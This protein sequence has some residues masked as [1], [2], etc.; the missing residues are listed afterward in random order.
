MT[1]RGR[2]VA[3]VMAEGLEGSE[4]VGL[5]GSRPHQLVHRLL[6]LQNLRSSERTNNPKKKKKSRELVRSFARP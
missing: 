5:G 6:L 2:T 1:T 3:V 4:V